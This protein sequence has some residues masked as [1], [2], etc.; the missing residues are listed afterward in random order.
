MD[1]LEL[2]ISYFFQHPELLQEALTHPSLPYESKNPQRH[3][4]RMEYL[5]DA[6]LQLVLSE[7]IYHQFPC[8]DEG[9]LTKLRTRLVQTRTLAHIAR[10]LG[11]GKDLLLGR[12]EESNG[13]RSRESTLADVMESIIG[14][15]YLDGGI[16]AARPFVL[17]HWETDLAALLH[18]P[19]ELNPKGQLQELLQGEGG[20]T[21]TY[22]IIAAEGP[23]HQKI[24]EAV[25]VWQGRDLAA[26]T[27]K[28]KKEAQTAAAEN[29]LKSPELVAM[30]EKVDVKG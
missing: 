8:D 29:A 11:L 15:V 25:V 28:S 27:G 5:G 6:V 24:F 21:P 1:S 4:Q 14:A 13:G 10:H 7:A 12:G 20:F 17:K 18:S 22:R 2:R 19:V 30:L 3:N 23:D 16:E 9:L 26:G